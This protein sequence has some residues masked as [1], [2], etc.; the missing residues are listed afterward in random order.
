M[1]LLGLPMKLVGNVQLNPE[2]VKTATLE[3][4]TE[5]RHYTIITIVNN[6]IFA[7]GND[8]VRQNSELVARD[9]GLLAP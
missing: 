3:E 5:A 1:N 4:Q 6:A 8:W 7:Q 2:Y 9:L